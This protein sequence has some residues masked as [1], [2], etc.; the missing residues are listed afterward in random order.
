MP[1][2]LWLCWHD[3][4]AVNALKGGVCA[5]WDISFPNVEISTHTRAHTRMLAHFLAG[6]G[7]FMQILGEGAGIK[8]SQS[9]VTS[10][11]RTSTY[12][13]GSGTSTYVVFIFCSYLN[14]VCLW[15]LL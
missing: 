5:I 2:S 8:L 1:I 12:L 14:T 4:C 6:G 15:F 9:S 7:V 11:I 13:I 3:T 10:E